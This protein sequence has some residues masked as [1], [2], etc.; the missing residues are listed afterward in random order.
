MIILNWLKKNKFNLLIWLSYLIVI[1]FFIFPIFWIF[2]LAIKIPSELFSYPPKLIPKHPT[3]MNFIKAWNTSSIPI[4]LYNSAK[5]VFFTVFG[6]LLVTIPAGYSFS[7]FTFKNKPLLLFVILIFQMI[8][9]IIIVIP[10]YIYYDKLGLLN[11]HFG[12]I[13]VYIAI[14]VPFTTWLLKGFFDSI[15]KELDDAAKVDGCSRFQ[16]LRKIILP[17]AMPGIA[18]A[19]IFISISAW[20]QFIMP[21]LLLSEDTLYPISVGIL[22]CQGTYQQ[23]SIH[24]LSAASVL[25]LA[26]AIAIVLILQKF[27]LK[28]LMAGAVKG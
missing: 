5:L 3:F 2:S 11:S 15:P 23:I 20:G 12:L 9:P 17:L 6:T 22:M 21:F 26:P 25:S 4:Y 18:S 24:L 19:T 28:A 10:I 14:Q 27:I 8:S 1:L 7:R 16:A 13:M